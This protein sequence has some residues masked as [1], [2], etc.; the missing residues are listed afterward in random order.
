M[1][2]LWINSVDIAGRFLCPIGLALEDVDPVPAFCRVP[3]IESKTKFQ[4][5]IEAGDPL[6]EIDPREVMNG[7]IGLR[8]QSDDGFEPALIR[9]SERC[10]DAQAKLGQATM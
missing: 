10:I 4:W 9:N 3:A 1:M 8:N 6:R 2:N 5:H 7:R